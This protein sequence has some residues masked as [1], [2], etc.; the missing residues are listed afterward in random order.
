LLRAVERLVRAGLRLRLL[1]VGEAHGSSDPTNVATTSAMRDLA[2][3]L[4]VEQQVTVTGHL[5]AAELSAVLAAGDLAVLPYVDG[6]AL[7]R[8][9]LLACLAHGLPVVT[10]TPQ[11]LPEIPFHQRVPPFDEPGQF[12]LDARVVASAPP[13]DDAAL[14]R[15]IYRLVDD[16]LRREKL[17]H[18]ARAFAAPLTW[19]AVARA[20]LAFYRRVL[21]GDDEASTE[22]SGNYAGT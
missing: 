8:S 9:S 5:A 17:A 11:P 10:T 14:A 19:D 20:T 13:G 16:P 22:F 12:R 7:N 3:S 18:A 15:T 1:L 21:Y 2:A 4:S 6:A